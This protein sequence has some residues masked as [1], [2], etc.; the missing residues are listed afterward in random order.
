MDGVTRTLAGRYE[1]VTVVGRGGMGTVYRA[2]DLLLDRVVAV[3]LLP[4]HLA[5]RD[6]TSVARFEREARAA[7]ALNNP[8]VVTVYDAGVD[9]TSRFIVM[10]LVDG[11]SLE[12]ILRDDGP[13]E[14]ARAMRIAAR[15]ADALAAAHAAGIVHRDIKPANVMLT[16]D[17]SVK[18]LDFGIARAIDATTLTHAASVVGTA[19]YMSPEQAR[20]EPA[21]ER[22]DIYALGCVLYAL[23]TGH[24]PFTGEGAAAIL[25]Q[26]ATVAPPS[27]RAENPQVP[28]ELDSFV[29]QMLA[30][31]GEQRPRTA[32]R[33]S[34]RLSSLAAADE[35]E[36]TVVAGTAPTAVM[37]PAPA[38]TSTTARMR[39][40]SGPLPHPRAGEPNRRRLLIAAAL[41]AAI[42]VVAIVLLTSHAGSA[43][44]ASTTPSGAADSGRTTSTNRATTTET[45]TAQTTSAVTTTTAGSAATQPAAP[46]T[47]SGTAGALTALATRDTQ[48]GTIDQQAAQQIESGLTNVL[49]SYEMGNTKNAQQQLGNLSQQVTMLEAQGHIERAA[50]PALNQALAHL[51]TALASAP[52]VTTKSPGGPTPAPGP[53]PGHS[54]QAPGHNKP[55]HNKPGH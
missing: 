3:K 14:P 17:G 15:V 22:S 18:V 16:N 26:H 48:S 10:E 24:P 55:G 1:L 20:G 41:A 2:R 40:R 4:E 12:A 23:L 44:K 32:V 27:P 46:A 29:M 6:P 45:T 11:R 53:G 8:A 31:S 5:E 37:S 43:P 21:D 52:T 51:S 38:V 39:P 35:T 47:V 36:P 54:A 49:N 19:A 13:L 7:G 9:D 33:V 50:A 30:K 28:A 34:D 25:H 42:V